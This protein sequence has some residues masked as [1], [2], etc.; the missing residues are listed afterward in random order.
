[1]EA[2]TSYQ[3]ILNS[4]SIAISHFLEKGGPENE[5]HAQN[6][7]KVYRLICKELNFENYVETSLAYNNED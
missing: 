3:E 4:L 7:K 6:L 2:S 5:Q 1:M